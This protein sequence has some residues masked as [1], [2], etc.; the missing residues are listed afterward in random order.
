[1]E[2]ASRPPEAD[3]LTPLDESLA[4]ELGQKIVGAVAPPSPFRRLLY[5]EITTQQYVAHL[6]EEAVRIS[7]QTKPPLAD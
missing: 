5:G 6:R 7:A 3:S 4:A 2:Q 1:M